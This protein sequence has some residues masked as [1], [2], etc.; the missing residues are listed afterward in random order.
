MSYLVSRFFTASVVSA[1]GMGISSHYSNWK[2]PNISG[3]ERF[4]G[5]LMHSAH[6]DTS[7]DYASKR[8]AVIGIGS[9]GIQILPKMA[10]DANHVDYFVRS[11]TWITPGRGINEATEDDPE[12]DDEYN[13]TP[14]EVERFCREPEYLQRHRQSLADRRIEG[15]V[16]GLGNKDAQERVREQLEASMTD[17]L[18][19]SAK[20]TR[21]AELI[22]PS[23]PV[24]CRRLTPGQGFL[25]AMVRDNVDTHWD[26]LEEITESGIRTKDGR[27]LELDA[28]VCATG[29]DTTFKPRFPIVGKSGVNL[30]DEWETKDPIAYFGVTVPKMPNYFCG[31]NGTEP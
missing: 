7:Y 19:S 6:W 30:A 28:I 27:L 24:G 29:F 16:K 31:Y 26:N 1:D 8:L 21:I 18:G 4:K 14:A 9:S 23:F 10:T 3:I 22:I 5:K 12:L 20:G 17:R 2:W 15:F 25:E 13:Y 11:H